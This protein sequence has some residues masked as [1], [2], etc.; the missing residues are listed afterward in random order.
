MECFRCENQATNLLVEPLV[1]MGT[2]ICSDCIDSIAGRLA[3]A[4]AGMIVIKIIFKNELKLEDA[5]NGN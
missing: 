3:C 2:P 1:K 5:S 4:V